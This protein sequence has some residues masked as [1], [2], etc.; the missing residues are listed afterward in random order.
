MIHLKENAKNIKTYLRETIWFLCKPWII[1]CIVAIP[2]ILYYIIVGILAER[3]LISYAV[4]CSIFVLVML[5]IVLRVRSVYKKMLLELFES[6]NPD[7]SVD[8]AISVDGEEYVIENLN[9]KTVSRLEKKKI[10]T[11]RYSKNLIFIKTSIGGV[12]IFPKT[13]EL[14]ALFNQ[15]PSNNGENNN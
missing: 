15:K 12:M 6:A 9:K 3:R 11:I 7:G 5:L 8:V 1:L 10:R 4:W 14:V 13:D 2:P